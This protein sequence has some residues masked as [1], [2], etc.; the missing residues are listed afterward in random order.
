MVNLDRTGWAWEWLRRDPGYD[1]RDVRADAQ[2]S[3]GP[4]LLQ[5][6]PDAGRGLL[7]RRG[8]W[9]AGLA[10]AHLL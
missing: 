9:H 2:M 5:E 1:G 10:R 6:A 7:F 4:I 3:H 8:R